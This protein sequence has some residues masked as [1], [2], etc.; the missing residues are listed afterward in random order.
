MRIELNQHAMTFEV[1]Q[2]QTV[3]ENV[4]FQR[5]LGNDVT[6]EIRTAFKANWRKWG[7]LDT[8]ALQ[9]EGTV[10]LAVDKIGVVFVHLSPEARMAVGL[11]GLSSCIGEMIYLLTCDPRCGKHELAH[12]ILRALGQIKDGEVSPRVLQLPGVNGVLAEAGHSYEHTVYGYLDS[13]ARA[14]AYCLDEPDV[15]EFE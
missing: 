9:D 13:G 6:S 5:G 4:L 15:P 11:R 12:T 8:L 10:N 2:A 1:L 3:A 7:G 14:R